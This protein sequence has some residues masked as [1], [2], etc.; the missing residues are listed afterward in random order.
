MAVDDS[1]PLDICHRFGTAESKGPW[2]NR[3]L[4]A[5][6]GVKGYFAYRPAEILVRITDLPEAVRII[7]DGQPD[8]PPKIETLIAGFAL[9]VGVADPV[10]VAT[11]L[12][13]AHVF[14]LPCV[15]S[16]RDSDN[17]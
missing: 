4:F 5:H 2:D 3:V 12:R 14:G 17:T 10:G 9:I 16:L 8:S 11:D 13:A 15:K 7:V 1:A 6:D